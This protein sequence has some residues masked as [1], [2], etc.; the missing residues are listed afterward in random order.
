MIVDELEYGEGWQ[1]HPGGEW[2][3][4]AEL[5]DTHLRVETVGPNLYIGFCYVL[6]VSGIARWKTLVHETAPDD[7]SKSDE[8]RW[9]ENHGAWH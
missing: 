2:A 5:W 6:P 1:S 9:R 3:P 8:Y 7:E 4:S